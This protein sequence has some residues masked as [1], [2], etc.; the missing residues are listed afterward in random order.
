KINLLI[1]GRSPQRGKNHAFFPFVNSLTREVSP[2]SYPQIP[3]LASL[4][5]TFISI[6]CFTRFNSIS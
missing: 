4:L 2:A 1:F 5:P 6:F 3:R